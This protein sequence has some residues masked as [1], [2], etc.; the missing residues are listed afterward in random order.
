MRS[1]E[2]ELLFGDF[3]FMSETAE[4]WRGDQIVALRPQATIVLRALLENRTRLTTRE[5]LRRE[6]WGETAVDWE[7]GLHQVV[8]QLRRALGDDSRHPVFIETVSGRGYRFIAPIVSPSPAPTV[9]AIPLPAPQPSRS[10]WRDA[11]LWLAGM[12]TLPTA[13]L[14]LCAFMA[15]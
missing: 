6:L 3:R 15:L 1:R 8:R 7:S 13:V 9:A 5:Q 14:L 10:P 4:L 2:D 12:L 11:A